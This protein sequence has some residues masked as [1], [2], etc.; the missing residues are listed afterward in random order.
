MLRR[1]KYRR[2]S[3]GPAKAPFGT[4][5]GANRHRRV[6]G[7]DSD[8][9]QF[10]HKDGAGVGLPALDPIVAERQESSQEEV[11]EPPRPVQGCRGR[12][13]GIHSD[14]NENRQ[15]DIAP[16][17]R[18]KKK[19][20]SAP[21]E[22][23]K[24]KQDPPNRGRA[25][26]PPHKQEQRARSKN[27]PRDKKRR[28]R[29]RSSPRKQG[30]YYRSW[31]RSCSPRRGKG[32]GR[33]RSPSPSPPPRHDSHKR[34]EKHGDFRSRPPPQTQSK[35]SCTSSHPHRDARFPPPHIASPNKLRL[36]TIDGGSVIYNLLYQN[37]DPDRRKQAKEFKQ[38]AK[39]FRHNLAEDLDD[40]ELIEKALKSR[41]GIARISKGPRGT[42]WKMGED[43]EE[44]VACL[45]G[46]KKVQVAPDGRCEKFDLFGEGVKPE[47]FEGCILLIST[48]VPSP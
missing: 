9:P 28:S 26:I 13:P 19:H 38:M 4:R 41:S 3:N 24:N 14:P 8:D 44:L 45:L 7:Y 1:P 37:S 30:G 6:S 40:D 21:K 23:P 47:E 10:Y 12:Q 16:D 34:P 27:P 43:S 17:Q 25:K 20:R 5:I 42:I 35:T 18:A 31:S 33:A 15:G 39:D 2:F 22:R 32:A 29:S 48:K 11:E 36:K 46:K